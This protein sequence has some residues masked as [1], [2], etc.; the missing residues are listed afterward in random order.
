MTFYSFVFVCFFFPKPIPFVLFAPQQNPQWLVLEI[1][2]TARSRLPMGW[3]MF[4][5]KH[6]KEDTAAFAMQIY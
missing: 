2:H 6:A 5:Q 3:S 4:T 1:T